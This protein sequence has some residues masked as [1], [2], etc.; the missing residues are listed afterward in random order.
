[1]GKRL[2]GYLIVGV[3]A[4]LIDIGLTV[5][6]ANFFHYVIANTLGFVVANVANFLLA[7]RWV[8]NHEFTIPQLTKA[9]PPL[10]A[11]SIVG[12]LLSDLLIYIFVGLMGLDLISGKVTTTALVLLWNF[13]GRIIF[14]YKYPSPK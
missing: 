14:V 12:L 5:Y 7:H 6:L 13:Y 8:F 3:I 10:L 9:Y 4:F 1:M 2:F 11:V